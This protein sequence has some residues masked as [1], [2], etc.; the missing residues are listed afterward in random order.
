MAAYHSAA[1]GEGGMAIAPRMD[2]RKDGDQ[3]PADR[4]WQAAITGDFV[5]M[6]KVNPVILRSTASGPQPRVKRGRSS[7]ISG[8][9]TRSQLVKGLR[10][11]STRPRH[12][13]VLSTKH[14]EKI[15]HDSLR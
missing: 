7:C 4:R 10:A 6:F 14:C 8:L 15:N 12:Q 5:L 9:T 1:P 13:A 11:A 2:G 3:L